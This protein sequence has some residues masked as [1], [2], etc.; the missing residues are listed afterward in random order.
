MACTASALYFNFYLDNIN[1]NLDKCLIIIRYIIYY[2]PI[3]TNQIMKLL[4]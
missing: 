1:F 2:D 3:M 4:G